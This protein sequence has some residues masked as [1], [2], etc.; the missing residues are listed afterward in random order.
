MTS[1]LWSYWGI[2]TLN[3]ELTSSLLLPTAAPA[4]AYRRSN[5]NKWVEISFMWLFRDGSGI[6]MTQMRHCSDREST[7]TWREPRELVRRGTKGSNIPS[8]SSDEESNFP[9]LSPI[10]R[11][12]GLISNQMICCAKSWRQKALPLQYCAWANDW[13]KFRME[14]VHHN[15]PHVH[16]VARL[17]HPTTVHVTNLQSKLSDDAGPH[18]PGTDRLWSTPSGLR[19]D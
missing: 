18:V 17:F 3:A 2:R 15:H 6:L 11:S 12:C 19:W 8:C 16:C 14:A 13:T 9:L 10:W 7:L 1:S 5:P 4:L